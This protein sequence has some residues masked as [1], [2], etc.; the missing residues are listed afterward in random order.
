[1]RVHYNVLV[2]ITIRATI[3]IVAKLARGTLLHHRTLPSMI[4]RGSVLHW[5]VE[6]SKSCFHGIPDELVC[7]RVSNMVRAF[8]Y[9]LVQECAAD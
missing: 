8:T 2:R 4:A 7:I 1:M 5:Y 3:P 6:A 9:T